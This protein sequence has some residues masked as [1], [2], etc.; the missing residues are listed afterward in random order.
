MADTSGGGAAFTDPA[1]VQTAAELGKALN[2][3]RGSRTYAELDEAA[4]ALQRAGGGV[5]RLPRSTVGDL[6]TKGRCERETLETFLA[7]CE[8]PRDRYER[9]LAAWERTRTQTAPVPGAVRVTMGT[10][11]LG[12]TYRF[13]DH[14]SLNVALGAGVTRDTPD[15][16][17]TT[18]VPVTF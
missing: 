7:A 14:V 6:V 5:A 15:L 1:R 16:T 10:L 9:W 8:V 2:V 17:V 4:R 12:G 18:R 3:L 11:L 13:N